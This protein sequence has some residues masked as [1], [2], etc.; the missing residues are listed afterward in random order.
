MTC[1]CRCPVPQSCP[2][3]RPR[4]PQHTGLLCPSQPLPTGTAA[5][6]AEAPGREPQQLGCGAQDPDFQHGGA[7]SHGEEASNPPAAPCLAWATARTGQLGN[8]R[9]RETPATQLIPAPTLPTRAQRPDPGDPHHGGGGALHPNAPSAAVPVA[10]G[11]QDPRDTRS[12]GKPW[13]CLKCSQRP[14]REETPKA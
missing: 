4:G 5:A 13:G 2:A 8:P 14:L 11:T 6:D 12:D 3:L 10:A 1:C 9:R 7:R